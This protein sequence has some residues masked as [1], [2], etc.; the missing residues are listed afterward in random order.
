MEHFSEDEVHAVILVGFL[1]TH[2]ALRALDSLPH[3]RVR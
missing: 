2:A 3:L 1:S